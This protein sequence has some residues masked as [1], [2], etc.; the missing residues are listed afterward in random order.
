MAKILHIETSGKNC[1]VAI[2]E[3]SQLIAHL[4]IEE[5]RSH[6]AHLSQMIINALAKAEIAANDLDA[7]AVSE[8]PGSYTGLR[9]GVSIAKG[10]CYAA[11]IPLIAIPTLEIM[12][13]H[14]K[15]EAEQKQMIP[16]DADLFIPMI[17]ARR[18]EVYN[19]IF[20]TQKRLVRKVQAEIIDQ[21]SFKSYLKTNTLV[22]FGDGSNK[23]QNII[24][25]KNTIFINGI[26]P[27]A[28]YMLEIAEQKFAESQFVNLAYYEPFYLKAFQAT[29]PKNSVLKNLQ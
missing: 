1:S 25:H 23:C 29:V 4:R 19:C 7:V 22:F 3:N 11:N 5:E 20:S 15:T 10:I 16:Q 2:S 13:A 12:L 21:N 14:L 18:M 26:L 9:I 28:Q 8:G 24:S 17:D 27:D 6:A